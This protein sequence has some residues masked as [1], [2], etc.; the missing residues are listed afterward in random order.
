MRQHYILNK[1][2][3]YA[4]FEMPPHQ[5]DFGEM[6]IAQQQML[7]TVREHGPLKLQPIYIKDSD[8][9]S[10]NDRATPTHNYNVTAVTSSGVFYQI[11][12]DDAI[13][14]QSDLIDAISA[15][16]AILQRGVEGLLLIPILPEQIPADRIIQVNNAIDIY[17]RSLPDRWD[18]GPAPYMFD[19]QVWWGMDIDIILWEI[20]A[21]II[22]DETIKYAFHFMQSSHEEFSIGDGNIRD[23]IIEH[24]NVPIQMFEAVKVE[25]AIHNSYKVIEAICGGPLSKSEPNL[26]ARLLERGIDPLEF[27]G[28]EAFG[29]YKRE[30]IITK[31]QAL[32]EARNDRAAH[33][34]IHANRKITFYEL[35]DFQALAHICL[36]RYVT[37]EH[38]T[39]KKTLI[40]GSWR[41]IIAG[42]KN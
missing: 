32:R 19:S 13:I 33:G 14:S 27:V 38:P 12:I 30:R 40:D 6:L 15:A 31:I 42:D 2:G 3:A 17:A 35:M 20:A 1:I 8:K 28:Y 18:Y 26:K 23:V 34:R 21:A 22:N 10:H 41:S 7:A 11:T 5:D 37:H 36:L 29:M 25:N 16:L 39:L 9:A 4:F 24:E